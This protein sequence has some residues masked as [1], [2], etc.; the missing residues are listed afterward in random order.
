MNDNQIK[1]F[2]YITLIMGGCFWF[3]LYSF[4][5]FDVLSTDSL[6]ALSSGI[7]LVVLF[8]T[9]YF[10][11]GW[12]WP[13]LRKIMFKPDMNG[14]WIG[15]FSSDWKDTDGNTREPA[16]FVLV[17]R[18]TWFS[19]SIQAFTELQTTASKVEKLIYDENAGLKLLAYI[20]SEEDSD[21]ENN[22]RKGAAQLS[23][24]EFGEQKRLSGHF[25]TY[26]GTKGKLE[27]KLMDSKLVVDD[28]STAIRYWEV[29][30]DWLT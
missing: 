4:Q 26:A 19:L 12:R 21:F 6:K 20:F 14:T 23:L 18:Q 16:K 9:L 15:K 17:I 22:I 30:E 5:Q 7:S 8:W 25:W 3:A 29:S 10:K 27:V 24:V 11:A 2:V 28:Y 13:F 1:T